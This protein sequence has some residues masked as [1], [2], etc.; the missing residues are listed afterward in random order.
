MSIH[1]LRASGLFYQFY[2]SHAIL[3][4]LYHTLRVRSAWQ[5]LYNHIQKERESSFSGKRLVL[6]SPTEVKRQ[7]RLLT[8]HQS[9]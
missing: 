3:T 9:R 7:T 6:V 2:R 1:V 8:P 4:V 5:S